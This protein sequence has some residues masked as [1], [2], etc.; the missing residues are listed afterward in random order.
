MRARTARERTTHGEVVPTIVCFFAGIYG[1]YF[2]AAQGIILLGT[3][4]TLLPDALARTN[5]LKNVLALTV[6]AVAAVVFVF[7]GHVD[8]LVVLLIAGGSVVGA[9]GGAHIGKRVPVRALRAFIV[10]LGL[11]V[12]V[13]LLLT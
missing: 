2:G 4:G 10:V 13:R 6:N 5:A 3:L 1:G 12:G 7:S 11:T 9:I 8:W